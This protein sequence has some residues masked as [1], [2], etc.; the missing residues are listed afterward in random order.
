MPNRANVA[1]SSSTEPLR[2]VAITINTDPHARMVADWGINEVLRPGRDFAVLLYCSDRASRRH[3]HTSEGARG[4][5]QGMV[6][7]EPGARMPSLEESEEL[8]DQGLLDVYGARCDQLGIPFKTILLRTDVPGAGGGGDV[9]H[10]LKKSLE[11]VNADVVVLGAGKRSR[12]GEVFFG[13]TSRWLTH[14]L[15]KPV[16]LISIPDKVIG[17]NHENQ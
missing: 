10:L 4:I 13:S 8:Q 15:Q 2:T 11:E 12:L 3:H 17:K 6:D 14:H 16:V 1:G 9:K 5:G 7:D